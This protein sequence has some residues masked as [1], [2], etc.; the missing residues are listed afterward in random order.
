VAS[1]RQG[2][3]AGSRVGVRSI[4]VGAAGS[5]SGTC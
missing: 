4:R 3:V 2:R 5:G 1:R